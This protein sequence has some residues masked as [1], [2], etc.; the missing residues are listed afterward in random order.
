AHGAALM[1]MRPLGTAIFTD[2]ICPFLTLTVWRYLNP[3]VSFTNS[4]TCGPSPS[5]IE[6]TD[7]PTTWPSLNTCSSIGDV[8]VTAPKRGPD[9]TTGA[10]AARL[11]S[12]VGLAAGVVSAA[13]DAAGVGVVATG[14]GAAGGGTGLVRAMSGDFTSTTALDDFVYG[15]TNS[16]TPSAAA[17]RTSAPMTHGT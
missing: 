6:P 5:A 10:A 12:A 15:S 16:A 1:L 9:G 11:A 13:T 4:S 2:V 3:S 14:G 8:T 17:T 7:D